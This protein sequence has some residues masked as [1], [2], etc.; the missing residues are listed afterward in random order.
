MVKMTYIC[1]LA[2]CKKGNDMRLS[3]MKDELQLLFPITYFLCALP[4]YLQTTKI[5]FYSFCRKPQCGKLE[6][7]QL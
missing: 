4:K 7:Y 5:G 6:K 1:K 2:F 3:K